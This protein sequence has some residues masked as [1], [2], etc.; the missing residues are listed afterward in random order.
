[1]PFLQSEEVRKL[2]SQINKARYLENV[3]KSGE[4]VGLLMDEAFE[5]W[6]VLEKNLAAKFDRGEITFQRY[7]TTA[8]AAFMGIMGNLEI[9]SHLLQQLNVASK[10]SADGLAKD[11]GARIDLGRRTLSELDRLGIELAKIETDS[12]QSSKSLESTLNE[13]SVLAERA[14]KYSKPNIDSSQGENE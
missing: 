1:V 3:G 8:E 13:L 10:G 12:A 11:I 5:K 2:K 9:A 14:H 6:K 4:A 7:Q